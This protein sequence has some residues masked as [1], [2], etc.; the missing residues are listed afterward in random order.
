MLSRRGFLGLFGSAA[1]AAT[2]DPERL[3]WVP[4]AKTISIPSPVIL[5]VEWTPKMYQVMTSINWKAFV[6]DDLGVFRDLTAR[7]AL[8][9]EKRMHA[10]TL[11]LYGGSM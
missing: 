3:L 5:Q 4:G 10:E 2:V 1:V 8:S 11:K 7:L 9:A 6:N